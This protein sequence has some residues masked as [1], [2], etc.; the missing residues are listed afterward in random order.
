[1]DAEHSCSGLA[2]GLEFLN[3]ELV[4]PDCLSFMSNC[5]FV[6]LRLKVEVQSVEHPPEKKLAR[7][8]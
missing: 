1:M 5:H 2:Q 7:R 4:R 8:D 6:D 3:Q